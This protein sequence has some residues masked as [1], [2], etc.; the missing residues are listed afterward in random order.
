MYRQKLASIISRIFHKLII[1][2]GVYR[3]PSSHR[4][5]CSGWPAYG[6]NGRKS[7]DVRRDVRFTCAVESRG[8]EV[9]RCSREAAGRRKR[10]CSG[11][12]TR[13]VRGTVVEIERSIEMG[14]RL[15][16]LRRPG[17]QKNGGLG[18]SE[19]PNLLW[20]V[21]TDSQRG[22]TCVCEVIRW[23]V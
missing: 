4:A 5:F 10:S 13:G 12:E 7:R 20:H 22:S 11:Q 18:C 17:T 16:A 19:A 15:E 21:G 2:T 8:V 23:N 1:I 9:A 14:D 3:E 6:H